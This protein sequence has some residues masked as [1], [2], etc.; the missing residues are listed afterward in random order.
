MAG[1]ITAPS[2]PG[3]N[4][5]KK[6]DIGQDYFWTWIG[7]QSR[8]NQVWMGLTQQGLN[9]FPG[10]E[11]H[12][13]QDDQEGMSLSSPNERRYRRYIVLPKA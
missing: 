12:N 11:L 1:R 13:L 7:P 5:Q 10:L 8:P 9:L 4:K 2:R 3:L 6:I